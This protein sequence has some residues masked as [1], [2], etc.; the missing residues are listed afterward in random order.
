MSG[1]MGGGQLQTSILNFFLP[2]NGFEATIAI[3]LF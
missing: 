3:R 2:G 1:F